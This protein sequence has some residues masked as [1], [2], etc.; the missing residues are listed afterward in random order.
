MWVYG[1]K[2]EEPQSI[3]MEHE[4]WR[5]G[6]RTRD[7]YGTEQSYIQ[8]QGMGWHILFL[9]CRENPDVQESLPF[10]NPSHPDTQ[11]FYE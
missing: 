8:N 2:R 11:N 6:G 3:R 4:A 5:G 9:G 7:E 10:P 1:N